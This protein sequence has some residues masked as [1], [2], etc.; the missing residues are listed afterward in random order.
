MIFSLISLALFIWILLV[1][2]GA[3]V[4]TTLI[5]HL[6]LIMGIGGAAILLAVPLINTLFMI[7]FQRAEQNLAPRLLDSV[8]QDWCLAWSNILLLLFPF[9]SF[10]FAFALLLFDNLHKTILIAVWILSFG[11]SLDLLRAIVKRSLGYMDPFKVIERFTNNAKK[12]NPKQ[13]R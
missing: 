12:A 13:S 8:S 2:Y 7:P 11:I 4:T 3:V 6:A 5:P 10:L 1:P 9:L